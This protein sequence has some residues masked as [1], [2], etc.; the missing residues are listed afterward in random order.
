[1][2]DKP[3]LQELLPVK[4]RLSFL[5]LERCVLN[6]A[7]NA[8]TVTDTRGTAH[9]PAGTISVLLL[10]P[11]TKITHRAMEL[12]GD[13]GVTVIWV[14]E[15]GVR[16]YAHGKPL[17]H[18]SRLL[19]AQAALVSNVQFRASVV[20]KMY[21]MRFPNENVAA[22]TIQ[23]LRGREGTRIRRVYQQASE[24]TGV[25]WFGREYDPD[26]Y[27]DSDPINQALSAAHACL[28]GLA[29]SVIVALGCSPGLGFVHNGHERSF[30]YDIADLYKAEVTIPIAFEVAA[31]T[32]PGDDI[33][34]ITRRAVRDAISDGRILERCA[35]DI[36][37]LLLDNEAQDEQSFNVDVLELWDNKS[38]SVASGVNY[39]KKPLESFDP[40]E[41]DAE[42]EGSGVLE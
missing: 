21:A 15:R 16:Y 8:I 31:K 7:E 17:T 33:G 23:Q 34:G 3:E 27:N 22:L 14:G 28:Y 40:E 20:R 6:R 39:S 25:P 9:V 5:Y 1:M 19:I 18:S 37:S 30:V 32:S 11:G 41:N 13:C 4:D 38:G 10:G 24:K 29:H 35:H 36:R 2:N 12:I 26:D 42:Q